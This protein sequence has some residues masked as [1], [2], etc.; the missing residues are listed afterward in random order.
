MT[1]T[2]GVTLMPTP[3]PFTKPTEFAN[4]ARALQSE[5]ARLG[6]AV[7]AFRA[8]PRTCEA[9][10]ISRHP[11]GVVVRV[12][13]DRD[14]HSVTADLVDG[15]IAANPELEGETIEMTR[16]ALWEAAGMAVAA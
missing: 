12:R 14:P 1:M 15:C 5:C 8:P 13:L 10:T 16:S 9:R 2:E 3:M 7:P 6:L 11:T 4:I